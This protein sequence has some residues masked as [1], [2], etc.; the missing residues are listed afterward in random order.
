MKI[1]IAYY[2]RYGHTL[3]MA[4]AVEDGVASA[5]GVEPV[6]RKRILASESRRLF[7]FCSNSFEV[8]SDSNQARNAAESQLQIK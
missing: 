5:K 8:T 6:F 3:Q 2:S 4:R 7:S 1:L